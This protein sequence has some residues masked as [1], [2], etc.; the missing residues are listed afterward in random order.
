LTGDIS[1]LREEMDYP[2]RTAAAAFEYHSRAKLNQALA[3]RGAA[4]TL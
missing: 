2:L 3:K 1:K 4:A